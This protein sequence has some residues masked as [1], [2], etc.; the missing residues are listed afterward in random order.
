MKQL[1][2][3]SFVAS[4]M[5]GAFSALAQS[6]TWN[7]TSGN[8][9]SA[10]SWVGGAIASG[11]DAT[12]TFN[13]TNTLTATLDG[14]YTIGTLKLTASTGSGFNLNGGASATTLTLAT[15]SGTPQMLLNTYYG[16]VYSFGSSG[17]LNFAGTQGVTIDA[18]TGL[19]TMRLYGGVTWSGFSGTVTLTEGYID[20][21][22]A[23]VM[24]TG[25]DL[26]LGTGSVVSGLGMYGAS[27]ATRDQTIG[28]LS[29][30]SLAYIY[31]NYYTANST[32][33]LGNTGNSGTFAGT[34]GK[35]SGDSSTTFRS[36]INITKTGAGTERFTGVNYYG[37]TTTINNGTLLVNGQHL[38]TVTASGN[39][40]AATGQGG[41]YQVNSGGV[42]GGT[43]TIKPF[44][45][46]GGTVM[47]NINN[48]GS[49]APGDPTANS[50]IGTLTID[51]SAASASVLILNSGSTLSYVLG[52]GNASSTLKLLNAQANDVFFNGNTINFTDLAGGSLS[53]GQYLLF[54]SDLASG[55]TYNG[56]T[57]DG[58]GY[59]T[60]GLNIGGGLSGYSSNLQQIGQNIYLDIT[61]VPEPATA[62]LLG[63]GIAG[64]GLMIRRQPAK[65]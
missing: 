36:D 30:N 60:A 6:G 23:N 7:V 35:N 64:L 46:L 12:A 8:W 49:L 38:A 25:S 27:G 31:N 26:V 5:L 20:P 62:S 65:A 44:D 17:H 32:L 39:V 9:S 11:T 16:K 34:I 52:A 14:N 29:G 13:L 61:P 28:A 48:G 1:K 57:E 21:Q 50:G 40:A 56:L 33:T 51:G 55:N 47:I 63:L 58:S 43:G 3:L 22:T 4:V 59:I 42:L 15:S 18:G 10:G 2:H 45:T 53:T 37:G 54:Q 24:P 41:K 19:N